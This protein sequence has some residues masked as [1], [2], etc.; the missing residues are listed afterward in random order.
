MLQKAIDAD[1]S[2]EAPYIQ[3]AQIYYS[4]NDFDS[5]MNILNLGIKILTAKNSKTLWRI[6]LALKTVI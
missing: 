2:E 4:K 1:K 5:L 6:I 3:L